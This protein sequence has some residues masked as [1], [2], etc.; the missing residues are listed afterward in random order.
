MTGKRK[1]SS[2][3]SINVKQG[4]ITNVKEEQNEDIVIKDT[5]VKTPRDLPGQIDENKWVMTKDEADSLLTDAGFDTLVTFEKIKMYPPT[6]FDGVTIQLSG[7]E[8]G[9]EWYTGDVVYELLAFVMSEYFHNSKIYLIT[10]T[11]E[12]GFYCLDEDVS[13][14][15]SKNLWPHTD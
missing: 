3:N 9:T 5:V 6:E 4:P 13:A 7:V 15:F 8:Q 1:L 14:V 10:F 11:D 12:G 2:G